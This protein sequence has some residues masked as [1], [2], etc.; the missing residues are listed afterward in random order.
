[1]IVRGT[2]GRN[3]PFPGILQKADPMVQRGKKL[4]GCCSTVCRMVIYRENFPID[5]VLIPD[6]LQAFG[7]ICFRIP[8]RDQDTRTIGRFAERWN[9]STGARP[10]R[11]YVLTF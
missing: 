4:N 6:R 2:Q 9:L 3:Y 5:I 1:M 8:K 11:G 7:N 10:V